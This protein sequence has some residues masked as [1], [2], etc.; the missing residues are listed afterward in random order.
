MI[1]ECWGKDF[2]FD[3][4]FCILLDSDVGTGIDIQDSVLVSV[5]RTFT[6]WLLQE[7]LCHYTADHET[8]VTENILKS[9]CTLLL[10]IANILL[11]INKQVP[12]KL[13]TIQVLFLVMYFKNKLFHQLVASVMY[14]A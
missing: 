12:R 7:L 14:M 3:N 2:L 6:S 1:L 11:I 5:T 9:Y 4:G 10:V 13:Y 8:D